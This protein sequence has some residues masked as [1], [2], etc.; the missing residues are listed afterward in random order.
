MRA[1]L[2]ASVITGIPVFLGID[3]ENWWDSSGLWNWFDTTAP[4]FD[5]ANIENV[6]WTGWTPDTAIKISWRNWGRQIRVKPQQ[7]IHAPKLMALYKQKLSSV[8]MI[9]VSWYVELSSEQKILLAGIKVGWE[10]SI[11][12]NSYYYP[13]GN[14]FY[15]R[16][17][18]NS[19]HDPITGTVEC[20]NVLSSHAMIVTAE[21]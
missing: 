6:E 16:W 14:T 17:P 8:I 19:S 12:W 7:N 1:F 5:P 20:Q 2:A 9:L 15:D 11:G 21:L 18:T 4:G 13:D 3:G 10:A